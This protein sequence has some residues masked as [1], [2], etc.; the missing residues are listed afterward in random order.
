MNDYTRYL[1][2]SFVRALPWVVG[3]WAI[4]SVGIALLQWLTDGIELG[5]SLRTA[6][7]LLPVA[8][9]LSPLVWLRWR[10]EARTSKALPAVWL[11]LLWAAITLPLAVGASVLI[12]NVLGVE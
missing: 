7:I 6:I 1:W 4:A 5:E 2:S 9:P 10:G 3:I 11:S 12:A 8:V